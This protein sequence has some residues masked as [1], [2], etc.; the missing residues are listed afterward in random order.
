M[1]QITIR[2]DRKS[3][4]Q[5]EELVKQTGLSMTMVVRWGLNELHGAGPHDP[6]GLGVRAQVQHKC[7]ENGRSIASWANT[8]GFGLPSVEVVLNRIQQGAGVLGFARGTI[9]ME[10][11]ARLQE[12]FPDILAGWGM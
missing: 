4:V 7:R 8:N 5:L 2:L 10:I 11:V 12:E 1:K 6:A 3:K 9:Q